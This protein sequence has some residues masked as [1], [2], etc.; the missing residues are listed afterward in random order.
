MTRE[1]VPMVAVATI[2]VAMLVIVGFTVMGPVPSDV[3]QQVNYAMAYGNQ[4]YGEGNFTLFNAQVIGSHGG[5]HLELDNDT[6]VHLHEV[7]DQ[8]L[9]KAY[10]EEANESVVSYA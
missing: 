8:E 10:W 9:R 6:I 5:L 3:Q 2:V 4:T 7:S 1:L